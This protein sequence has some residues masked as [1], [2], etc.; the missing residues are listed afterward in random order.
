MAKSKRLFKN[1]LPAQRVVLIFITCLLALQLG[2]LALTQI[3]L[4]GL[5]F[6]LWDALVRGGTALGDFVTKANLWL[7]K[8]FTFML[9]AAGVLNLMHCYFKTSVALENKQGFTGAM[10]LMLNLWFGY[11]YYLHIDITLPYSAGL[12]ARVV[13]FSGLAMVLVGIASW[14][15][16]D[17]ST[18]EG[19]LLAVYIFVSVFA[20]LATGFHGQD[21]RE[22]SFWLYQLP[23]AF[24]HLA[25]A[26]AG[27][28]VWLQLSS[29]LTRQDKLRKMSHKDY[30]PEADTTEAL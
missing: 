9:C 10:L 15:N 12:Y 7:A 11:V 30:V 6:T 26:I 1:A 23:N 18:D 25:A 28:V 27:L 29:A 16:T 14:L 17:E 5:T 24:M 2:S 3:Q 20:C 22:V 21:N 19:G 8:N 13:L 4:P